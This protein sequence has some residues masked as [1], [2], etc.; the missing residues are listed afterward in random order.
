MVEE[1]RVVEKIESQNKSYDDIVKDLINDETLYMRDLNMII[2]VFRQ[3]FI[4]LFPNS[5]VSAKVCNQSF[6]E[7]FHSKTCR[8]RKVFSH[9][10]YVY[11]GRHHIVGCLFD[12]TLRTSSVTSSTFSR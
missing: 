2:K 7:L 12:R 4:E 5:K 6:I 9:V 10:I 11:I 8:P 1:E 3:P